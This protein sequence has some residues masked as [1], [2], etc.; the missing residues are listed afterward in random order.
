MT[1]RQSE[2]RRKNGAEPG[3]KPD[4]TTPQDEVMKV[5]RKETGTAGPDGPDAREVGDTFKQPPGQDGR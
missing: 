3:G 5:G 1:E 4:Q 2:G